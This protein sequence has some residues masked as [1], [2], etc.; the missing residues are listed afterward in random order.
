MPTKALYKPLLS[1]NN[2]GWFIKPNSLSFKSGIGDRKVRT[3][4][5]GGTLQTYVT[6]DIETQR[7]Y[8]KCIVYTDV[9]AIRNIETAQLNFDTNAISW[10]EHGESG[11]MTNATITNDP[12]INTG[13]DGETEIMFEGDPFV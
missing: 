4:S 5:A 1:V 8:L 6:E 13:V 2:I 10:Q 9:E 11:S 7:G 3:A 12:E